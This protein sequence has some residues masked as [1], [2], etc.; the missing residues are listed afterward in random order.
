MV[1]VDTNWV[2]VARS[3]GRGALGASRSAA[4]PAA[5]SAADTVSHGANPRASAIALCLTLLP[6]LASSSR[7]A[8]EYGLCG[9]EPG[10]NVLAVARLGNTVYLAGNF[11]SVG[12]N[13]GGGVP[14]TLSS[15]APQRPF[16]RVTGQVFTAVSDTRGGWFIGGR[17]TA[18]DGRPRSNLAHV[19]N[20]GS[21]APWSPAADGDVVSLA[22]WGRTLYIGGW[23]DHLGG[24]AR[25]RIGAVDAESGLV[26]DWAPEVPDYWGSVNA[27]AADRGIIY[28][29]GFFSYL[30][31]KRRN[32]IAALDARTGVATDWDPEAQSTVNA[33]AVTGN[34]VYAGGFFTAIGGQTRNMIAALD[35]TTGLATA[36][37]ARASGTRP[38]QYVPQNGVYCLVADGKMVY[39]GGY[40]DHMGGRER[41][42]L[43]QLD[44]TTGDAT[45]WDPGLGGTPYVYGLAVHHGV[46]YAG[47]AFSGMGGQARSYI[48]A[49]DAKSALATEW[50]PRPNSTVQCVCASDNGVY[51]G[52]FFG[53]V[54]DW[55]RR[56]H[57]A[58]LDATTGAV[59]D[60]NPNP[61]G[62]V[63]VL[64]VHQGT[65]YAGGNFGNIGGQYRS[66]IAALDT[67]TGA[68]TDW[69]PGANGAVGTMFVSDSTL[70][71]AG[72]LRIHRGEVP[73]PCR[74]GGSR[75]R[76]GERLGSPTR[77]CCV[78]DG[79]PRGYDLPGRVLHA[80]RWTATSS[81]GCRGCNDR[82]YFARGTP[83][84]TAS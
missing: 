48:A 10:S 43:A 36:F 68:A 21:V 64:A 80:R 84:W 13:T 39:A 41:I 63:T 75:D 20:D 42:S 70:Y 50:D 54:W 18:V 76:S 31:G 35:V 15:G 78:R 32:C 6:L 46:V 24:I 7:A 82:A 26:V 56:V 47:G 1:T 60:W 29:G 57:I 40:F 30:G 16:A 17:F 73:Q 44:G 65:V 49:L 37:D 83:T 55:R 3:L 12:P 8:V 61:D 51:V 69:N 81:P 34:V 4:N 28:A 62:Y 52:G 23:F 45:G 27:L 9:V 71:L 33:L 11:R 66:S 72:G 5:R 53:S 2:A 67:L 19:L 74:R 25:R 77:R 59:R 38:N 22:R 58:A 79:A 14:V